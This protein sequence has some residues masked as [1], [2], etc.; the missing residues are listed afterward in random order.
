MKNNKLLFAE[1]A[2]SRVR[3]IRNNPLTERR[4]SE[5]SD[6]LSACQNIYNSGIIFPQGGVSAKRNGT[7]NIDEI[8]S[9]VAEKIYNYLSDENNAEI[10]CKCFDELH[11][12]I[13]TEFLDSLNNARQSVGYVELCYGSAQKF[14]NMV[15]KYLSCY[16]DFSSY[17]DHFKWCHMPIDT[18]ILKWLKDNYNITSIKYYV[19]FNKKGKATLSAKYKNNPWTKFSKNLY[20]DLLDVIREKV[21]IDNRFSGKTILEAEFSIWSY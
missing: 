2:A 13:C 20:T 16:S 10:S 1:Y 6:I 9:N 7:P 3:D 8:L 11:N 17:K 19:Y 5:Y 18:V 21:S 12:A 4:I 14:I 15:F